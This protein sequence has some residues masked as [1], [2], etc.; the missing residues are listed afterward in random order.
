MR[1]KNGGMSK[2]SS[3]LK[4]ASAKV[5]YYII[6]REKNSVKRYPQYYRVLTIGPYQTIS[7]EAPVEVSSVNIL[8][9]PIPVRTSFL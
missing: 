5:I 7:L 2:Y 6:F 8:L 4:S 3:H 1:Q 9:S